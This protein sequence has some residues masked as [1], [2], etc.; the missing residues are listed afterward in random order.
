VKQAR[1]LRIALWTLGAAL[2]LRVALAWLLVPVLGWVAAGRGLE[3]RI[4][5]HSLS[6]L[7][8]ELVIETLQVRERDAR[9]APR[10]AP[11]LELDLARIDLDG[12]AL[13]RGAVVVER[14]ELDGL[15]ATLERGADGQLNWARHFAGG[16]A[17][18]PAPEVREPV[19]LNLE[20]PVVLEEVRISEIELAL[21]DRSAAQPLEARVE[22][23][24][25][26][27]G[28]GSRE[29][30]GDFRLYS[31]SPGRLESLRIEGRLFS[32]ARKLDLELEVALE[33]LQLETGSHSGR[34]KLHARVD[35]LENDAAAGEL[36]LDELALE[37]NG[38][39]LLE[40]ANARVGIEALRP[41]SLALSGARIESAA[42]A[43]PLGDTEPLRVELTAAELGPLQLSQPM[44]EQ[45][46]AWQLALR[47]PG[48]F[49][50]LQA[51]GRYSSRADGGSLSVDL[52][53]QAV[54]LRRLEPVLETFGWRPALVNGA[55]EL[56]AQSS[57]DRSGWQAQLE[58]LSWADAEAL[59]QLQSARLAQLEPFALELGALEADL[60]VLADGRVRALGLES[61]APLAPPNP[62]GLAL[63]A[64]L[65]ELSVRQSGQQWQAQLVAALAPLLAQARLEAR[66]EETR[67]EGSWKLE[68]IQLEPLRPLLE[69]LGI[70]PTL[71]EGQCSGRW[72]A[73]QAGELW[74]LRLDEARL[75]SGGQQ[76]LGLES[77]EWLGLD[78][79]AQTSRELRVG[80]LAL[81]LGRDAQGHLLLPALRLE[82][83]RRSSSGAPAASAPGALSAPQLP[84]LP[85]LLPSSVA[86]EG[87]IGWSDASRAVELSVPLNLKLRAL[88]QLGGAGARVQLE[89]GL[90]SERALRLDATLRLPPGKLEGDLDLA[91][92]P[93]ALEVLQ[94]YLPAEWRIGSAPWRAR[95]RSAWKIANH[96]AGGVRADWSLRDVELSRADDPT[97]WLSLSALEAQVARVDPLAA[98]F[99][100]EQLKLAG[101]GVRVRRASDGSVA[102]LGLRSAEPWLAPG[103]ERDTSLTLD[104][105]RKPAV[106]G[107]RAYGWVLRLG[108]PGFVEALQLDLGAEE[109]APKSWNFGLELAAEGLGAGA[110]L[111]SVPELSERVR[112]EE[113]E[114]A[115]LRARLE[116]KLAFGQTLSG[117]LSLRDLELRSADSQPLAGLAALELDGLRISPKTQKLS[118]GE[119]RV[120]TPLLRIVRDEQGLKLAGLRLLEASAAQASSAP[121]APP[122]GTALPG[123]ALPGSDAPVPA[124]AAPDLALRHVDV[125]GLDLEFTD[126]RGGV[127]KSLRLEALDFELGR[128]STSGLASGKSLSFHGSVRGGLLELPKVHRSGSLFAL[129]AQAGGSLLRGGANE[130]VETEMRPWME[131]LDLRGRIALQ[132]ELSGWLQVH[133]VALELLGLRDW[134]REQGIEIGDGTL[135]N[136][137][138]LRLRG[139]EGIGI[140][141]DAVFTHLSLSEPSGGPISSLLR[142][143]APLDTVLFLLKND[144]DEH[145][146]SVRLAVDPSQQGGGPGSGAV[147]NAAVGAV[148]AVIAQAVASSPFRLLSGVGALIG[149]QPE[150][151]MEARALSFAPGSVELTNEAGAALQ[152]LLRRYRDDE[153]RRFVLQSLLGRQDLEWAELRANPTLADA[154]ALSQRLRQRKAEIQRERAERLTRIRVDLA[155]LAGD[156]AARERSLLAALDVELGGIESGL[157]QLH[158]RFDDGDERRKETRTKRFCLS[159][160]RERAARLRQRLYEAGVRPERVELRPVKLELMQ[161]AAGGLMR[162]E[163]RKRNG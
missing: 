93:L 29:R 57:W 43:W 145:R 143:P 129:L 150:A 95:L 28:I 41:R 118:A 100:P 42:A 162:I 6:L 160:A 78:P 112:A 82:P 157:D 44:P 87:Q 148:A 12:S 20:L 79:K 60:S 4:H 23:E 26:A 144:A 35:P 140:R 110:L 36:V 40:L 66:L 16:S 32:V 155:T 152:Q 15:R 132:P 81:Q 159:L 151:P 25:S 50:A 130:K 85:T 91:L 133:V 142:L 128:V 21:I 147:L 90:D 135:D 139:R 33:A 92:E 98:V 94:P 122:A 102:L 68:G 131:E 5:E 9:G 101:L 116:A 30:V 74:D 18:S 51:G 37:R 158:E 97:P 121:A 138:M 153:R 53:A 136:T 86:R 31:H 67:M 120:R 96:E 137:L 11:M 75:F 89:S 119:L 58:R 156:E 54:T 125:E 10:G 72:S 56:S 127:P 104:L 103:P 49:E 146:V 71:A 3:L 70:V 134:A 14:V 38:R 34:L 154:L 117:S 123:T 64:R 65:S 59:L 105:E 17:D 111:G 84:A 13:L 80:G 46:C 61:L 77:I 106:G 27:S 62:A 83:E 39:S 48:V 22:A 45:N 52:R 76:E 8:L 99:V 141:N 55:L 1:W 114:G 109:L 113:L 73:Q 2:L 108:L 7:H 149:V 126:L 163:I 69:P 124:A 88:D 63:R 115:R 47:A 161:E 19:P 107:A 24:F